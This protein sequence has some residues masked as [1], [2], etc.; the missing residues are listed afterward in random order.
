[1]GLVNLGFCFA[2]FF[3]SILEDKKGVGFVELTDY[4]TLY[5]KLEEGFAENVKTVDIE[6]E[7]RLEV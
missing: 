2:I 3:E 5:H 4:D 1:M 6:N 7:I